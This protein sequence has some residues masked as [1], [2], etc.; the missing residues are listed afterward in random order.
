MKI[1]N[2]KFRGGSGGG[3]FDC[4]EC[5]SLTSQPRRSGLAFQF[6]DSPTLSGRGGAICLAAP[7]YEGGVGF[8]EPGWRSLFP[9]ERSERRETLGIPTPPLPEVPGRTQSG[10]AA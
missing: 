7:G 2:S 9:G 6:G 1:R 10:V 5:T 8:V 3:D 4:G